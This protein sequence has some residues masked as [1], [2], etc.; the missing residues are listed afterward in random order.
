[1]ASALGRGEGHLGGSGIDAALLAQ[2]GWH[3]AD[4]GQA[5]LQVLLARMLVTGLLA[6]VLCSLQMVLWRQVVGGAWRR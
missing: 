6:P 4:L 3:L 2:P 5:G 1:V